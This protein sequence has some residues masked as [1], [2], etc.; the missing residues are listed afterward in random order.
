M[1]CKDHMKKRFLFVTSTLAA[2]EA[3]WVFCTRLLKEE[4][5]LAVMGPAGMYVPEGVQ[6]FSRLTE[7]R[8][9]E[10][11]VVVPL[12]EVSI[13]AVQGIFTEKKPKFLNR[14]PLAYQMASSRSFGLSLLAKAGIPTVPYHVINNP[15]D[16]L[17]LRSKEQ[18]SDM[19]WDVFTD[20][21]DFL[22]PLPGGSALEDIPSGTIGIEDVMHD[23][24]VQLAF[25]LSGRNLVKPCFAYTELRGLLARGGIQDFR[26]QVV[27]PISGPEVSKVA[28][29]IR[30]AVSAIGANGFVF[31][32]LLYDQGKPMVSRVSLTPP[33]GF[34]AALFL[35]DLLQQSLAQALYSTSKGIPFKWQIKWDT[36]A[37]AH[38]VTDSCPGAPDSSDLPETNG[39]EF[40]TTPFADNRYEVG[41]SIS[42]TP[43]VAGS[44]WELRPTAEVKL[45]SAD[46]L[47]KTLSVLRE[48]NLFGTKKKETPE[49]EPVEGEAEEV[50][51]AVQ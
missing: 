36:Q 3:V 23:H 25:L 21:P 18:N 46:V 28:E 10:P 1:K 24:K 2:S 9:F 35:S 37:F 19:P 38:L 11:D 27:I 17:R 6:L 5:T 48:L 34:L 7:A 12:D 4:Q 51:H 43:E 20:H 26:G 39:P 50:V 49:E 44:L 30:S 41:Y 22:V 45:N 40:F 15:G 47:E 42:C 14:E 13:R 29:Q 33:K 16:V 31:V 8:E 32:D